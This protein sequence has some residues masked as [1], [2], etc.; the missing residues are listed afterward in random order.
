MDDR[1]ISRLEDTEQKYM[2]LEEMMAQ[3]DIS[4]DPKRLMEVARQRSEMTPLVE[5][6][7]RYMDF[8]RQVI[9][10]EEMRDGPDPEMAQMA[11]EE[12]E[13]V[14]E[15]RDRTFDEIKRLLLP[16]DPNDDKNVIIEVRAGAGGEEAALFASEIYGMYARNA[17]KHSW[18]TEVLSSNPSDIG[19]MKEIIFEVRGR[20]AYSHFKYESGVHRVQ[21][22][23]ATESQGRIHTS[24]V[25]VSVMPEAEEMDLEL[26]DE[27]IRVDVYRA[28]G[29]GGQGVNRTDSAVRLTHIPSG[30]VVTCQDERSQ[31]K[32]KI[33]A[34]VVLRS[35][36]YDLELSKR[37]QELGDERRSQVGTGDRSEKIR[38]YNYPDDRVTD[39]RI[40]LTVSSVPRVL[41]G[42][43]DNIIDTLR[44]TDMSERLKAAG[45]DGA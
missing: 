45:L 13:H 4:T 5:A 44:L 42:E 10:A 18:K 39:H 41:E 22:V 2:Q 35:R 37:Q 36:L 30:I 32:N 11:R 7:R 9:E 34:M 19:G 27:D 12:L 23:P 3:P 31:L 40:K 14:V 26:R 33:R 15:Q 28:S 6:Y 43:I 38:T 21:R 25:T 16:K 1:L 17:E 20:G 29:H 24:T 8:N